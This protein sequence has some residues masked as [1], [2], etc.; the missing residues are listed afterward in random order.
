VTP[1]TREAAARV[2]RDHSGRVLATLIR[3]LGD[4]DRAEDALQDAL[5]RALETW[6]E[7]G[8]PDEP[9]AWLITTA[10]NKAIDRL[11][12]ERNFAAKQDEIR[13]TVER[14]SPAPDAEDDSHIA[15]DQL[16]LI[17]T[18]CHPALSM[19]ARVALT[20]RTLGGLTT[21]EI[22]RAF[23]VPEA[24]MAQ[25]LVRAKKKIRLAGIPYQVPDASRLPE[26]LDGVLAVLYLIFNEGYAAS[27]GDVLVRQDLSSEAIRLSKLVCELAPDEPEALGLTALMLLHD[28][29]RTARVS[30]SGEL[31]TLEEQNR[32][33]W[34]KK[35]I[36]LGL[37][38]LDR[39]MR[40]RRPRSYQ[41]Q[42][43]ISACHASAASAE[44]T[45]WT[46][47]VELY[48][49][50]WKLTSSPIVA[51]NR[52]AAIG[53]A[54]GPEDGL[55]ELEQVA[56]LGDYYLLHAARAD[57]LRRSGRLQEAASAYDEALAHVTNDTE[58]SY[59]RR[60]RRD[61]PGVR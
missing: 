20:L 31:V 45:N 22:A 50:L 61:L 11:R 10:R 4:F 54:R 44:A 28:A 14:W 55:K 39:A 32:A 49:H 35:Q 30:D 1:S 16:K 13:M 2:F 23:L 25:R 58:R 53:M 33:L 51:L 42:A 27:A 8:I 37:T 19:E 9:A 18:A 34:D 21:R 15:D 52:A 36:F 3:Q 7:A 46:R 26:R 57:L 29:R 59:L 38:Y 17:F 41:L 5:T 48:D 40:L 24:T 43:A 47:I 56:S 60:R 6:P 12:R